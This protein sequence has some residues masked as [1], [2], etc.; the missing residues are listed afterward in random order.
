MPAMTVEQL[1]EA[2][3][4]TREVGY[5]QTGTYG[6]ASD[7]VLQAVREAMKAEAHHGP[8]TPAGRASH[9]EKEIA[10]RAGLARLLNVKDEELAIVTNTSRAMQQ[11]I[12]GI[13][14]QAGDEFLMTNLE[15]VSTYGVSHELEQEY[16]VKVKVVPGDEG[17]DALLES[18]TASITDRT[19]LVCLSHMSSPD[20]RLLPIKDAAKIAHDWGVPVVLDVAQTVGQMP[21]DLADLGS[22]FVVGSGHKWLLGPM[23]TGFVVIAEGQIP[24]VRPNFI[25]DRSPWALEGTPT[26]TPTAKSRAEIG[27][28]NH[29]LV[30]GLGKAVEIADSVGLDT[31]Q[32]AAR[33]LT[34]TLRKEAANMNI[35]LNWYLSDNTAS[36]WGSAAENPPDPEFIEMV[37]KKRTIVDPVEREA[38]V[39]DIAAYIC[40]NAQ[41]IHAYTIPAL[42]ALSPNVPELSFN[43]SF[44]MSIPSE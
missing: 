41:A 20:G 38:V 2:I 28:Y 27:T 10:A 14:W 34:V 4:M 42:Y 22:D 40:D 37:N 18:L 33:K 44:Q 7:P 3:P 9:V 39:K 19:K 24:N 43:R 23:G 15:H 16:G 13:K 21:V 29:A 5:F 26:P 6:P 11:V 36:M 12:R 8:A 35:G 25:P 32:D 31:I 17:D 1:R 30:V